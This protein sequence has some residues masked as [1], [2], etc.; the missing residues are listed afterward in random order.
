MFFLNGPTLA[1]GLF[2]IYFYLTKSKDSLF[3]ELLAATSKSNNPKDPAPTEAVQADDEDD[4]A[5]DEEDDDE[6][7]GEARQAEDELVFVNNDGQF[8]PEVRL[9]EAHGKRVILAHFS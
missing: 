1:S 5:E 7:Q 8:E 4:A 3:A 2:F 9:A 6:G